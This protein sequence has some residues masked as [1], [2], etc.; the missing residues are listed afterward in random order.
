[1]PEQNKVFQPVSIAEWEAQIR[2]DLRGKP[3]ESLLSYSTDQIP[4]MPAYHYQPEAA[5]P[6]PLPGGAMRVYAELWVEDALV[7]NKLILKLLKNGAEGLK[8]RLQRALPP[9]EVLRGVDLRLIRLLV[10]YENPEAA[11]Q[12][13]QWQSYLRENAPH[14]PFT[15]IAA[16]D[17]GALK[18]YYPEPPLLPQ[19]GAGAIVDNTVFAAAGASEAQQL[20][21]AL[22]VAYEHSL[23]FAERQTPAYLHLEMATG[24]D[25]FAE[26]AKGRAWPL[27]WKN[28]EDTVDIPLPNLQ[29]G[30]TATPVNKTSGD[31]H[32][33]LIRTT[34]EGMA[35]LLGGA[36]ELSLP[37]FTSTYDRQQEFAHLLALKQLLV[38]RYESYLDKTADPAAGAY[39][40]EYLTEEMAH[41]GWEFF[42]AIEAEGGYK[43]ALGTGMIQEALVQMARQQEEHFEQGAKALVGA[44][45]YW[46]SGNIP[47]AYDLDERAEKGPALARLRWAQQLEKKYHQKK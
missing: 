9:K 1:M 29:R 42:K 13:S 25:Y 24:S 32:N 4:I 37:P 41:R 38:L 43:K 33:N 18:A 31:A 11:Q 2:K 30:A 28:L 26:I 14:E 22:A 16:A 40:L 35:A 23:A 39:Y 12:A 8:L 45:Q 19:E 46:P 27:L 20:G 7:S 34:A 47:L 3:L 21:L 44:H 17:S 36:T 15:A 6:E 5:A 10:F